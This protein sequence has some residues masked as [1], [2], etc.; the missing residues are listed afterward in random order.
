[1]SD[2]LLGKVRNRE[3]NDC[4]GNCVGIDQISVDFSEKCCQRK[5]LVLN[6]TFGATTVFSRL[7]LVNLYCLF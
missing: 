6:F 1:M 3:F 4:E 7:L 5:L 2:L